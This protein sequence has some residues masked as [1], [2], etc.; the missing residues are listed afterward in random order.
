MEYP[1][2]RYFNKLCHNNK[3]PCSYVIVNITIV[4]V[5]IITATTKPLAVV[6]CIHGLYDIHFID[7]AATKSS[8]TKCKELDTGKLLV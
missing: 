1:P 8:S 6:R 3:I 5:G 7:A 2:L 4:V